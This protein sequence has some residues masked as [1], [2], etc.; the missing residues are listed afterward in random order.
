[1]RFLVV[2]LL[3]FVVGCDATQTLPPVRSAEVESIADAK[4]EAK[5]IAEQTCNYAGFMS[6][7]AAFDDYGAQKFDCDR[8]EYVLTLG[9]CHSYHET[10]YSFEIGEMARFRYSE[11]LLMKPVCVGN[12]K[13]REKNPAYYLVP[14]RSKRSAKPLI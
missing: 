14:L 8:S 4:A 10:F 6:G 13:N 5:L 9:Q 12:A 7:D 3:L 2:S 11:Q 1:M